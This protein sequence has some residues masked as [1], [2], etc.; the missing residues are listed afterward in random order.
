MKLCFLLFFLLLVSASFSQNLSAEYIRANNI[1]NDRGNKSNFKDELVAIFATY[2]IENDSLVNWRH[3]SILTFNDTLLRENINLSIPLVNLNPQDLIL[4]MLVQRKSKSQ[5]QQISEAIKKSFLDYVNFPRNLFIEKMRYALQNDF[6]V[7][8]KFYRVQD[9]KELNK[10][11]LIKG[12]NILSKY[13]YEIGLN[14]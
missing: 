6:L 3:S 9:L 7:H 10:P 5:P 12:M 2:S 11:Y 4:I 1:I 14:F 8:L 13:E